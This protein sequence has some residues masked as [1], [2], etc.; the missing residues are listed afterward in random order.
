MV[1]DATRN[2]ENE[3]SE[4]SRNAENRRY[5]P[6]RP[7]PRTKTTPRHKYRLSACSP[8]DNASKTAGV[9]HHKQQTKFRITITK[10]TANRE[11]RDYH[12]SAHART[13]A[14]LR[15]KHLHACR[16][17][18]ARGGVAQTAQQRSRPATESKNAKRE[19]HAPRSGA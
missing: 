4:N 14:P 8:L 2:N 6:E 17:H 9:D 12:C 16:A 5:G 10:K 19:P 15:R 1:K 13:H 7:Y 18:G 11:P 3:I